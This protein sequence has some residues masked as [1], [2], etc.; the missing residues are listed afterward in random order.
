VDR[1]LLAPS[2]IDVVKI[3]Q[4]LDR[5]LASK[6]FRQVDRLQRFLG[7]IV[8]ESLSG[9]GDNLKEFLIGI[10]VFGKEAS[11]DPRMDPIVRVQARRLRIRL[12][13]YYREEGRNDEI[14]IELP[15]GGYAPLF[16]KTE[17][18][19]PRHSV[20]SVLSSRNTITIVP[21]ADDSHDHDLAYFC[22]GLTE[23]I[24]HTL[25][26]VK[27][28]RVIQWAAGDDR[29]EVSTPVSAAMRIS[30][31]VRRT[32]NILRIT[33]HVVDTVSRRYLWSTAIDRP[34]EDGIALQEEVARLVSEKLQGELSGAGHKA[35]DRPTENLAAYNFYLQ[36]RHRLAQ[37]TEDGLRKAAEFFDKALVEDPQYAQAY[38]GL[39][40][41]HGL[42]GHYGVLSP[43]EVCTKAASAAA[44]AVLLDD[45]S[46]E[47][48]TSLAHT[49][50]TQ[51]W[52]F[53]GA[54][55]EFQRAISLDPRYATAHHWYCT[56]CLTPL[57]RMDEALQEIQI[58]HALDPISSIISRD[59]AMTHYWRR[60]LETALE[61]SDR[62]IEQ[63][64]HFEGA[65]WA[66]GLIQ[67]QR[68]DLDES[69]AAFR[70]GIQLA[71]Q[72]P[73]M[74]SG[75]ARTLAASGR[76]AEAFEILAELH[77]LS[78]KRYVSPFE[79]A[80]VHF[81]LGNDDEAYEWLTNAFQS[82]C[83]ELIFAKVD[84][85]VDAR[86]GDARFKKLLAQLGVA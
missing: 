58:A 26:N 72:S 46:A 56:S 44:W 24:V 34:F 64:P 5:I 82:R 59:V 83:F 15:K 25:T 10:E 19:E 65:Y 47:A 53:L 9:S 63:N 50:G 55:R 38:S 81:A 60:D 77:D 54:E 29:A 62:T 75:L 66:L 49:K 68:G 78:K 84:P 11:F 22:R 27:A 13:R 86:R 32:R 30:G 1:T 37:R 73:R 42:L 57:G 70:R 51:D 35:A 79:L 85:R 71:P 23:E 20:A 7:F 17:S 33:V 48:H 43:V 41:A 61:Q 12:A 4:Q 52:D 21:F 74:R 28:L 18:T 31:N 67:E 76:R 3:R 16:Q 14:L 45:D 80:S 39:A 40:D 2:S 6:V 69:A 8:N 36:G